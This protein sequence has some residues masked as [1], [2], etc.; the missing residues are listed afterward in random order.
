MLNTKQFKK[1]NNAS[2]IYNNLVILFATG[3]N[4]PDGVQLEGH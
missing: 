3:F 1:R 2:V 4:I